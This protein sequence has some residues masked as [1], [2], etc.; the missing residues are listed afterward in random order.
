MTLSENKTEN[1]D[2]HFKIHKQLQNH[3]TW[4]QIWSNYT[5]HGLYPMPFGVVWKIFW[6]LHIKTCLAWDDHIGPA[7]G[8]AKPFASSTDIQAQTNKQ[9]QNKS[10][11]PTG[12]K[13]KHWSDVTNQLLLVQWFIWHTNS[14]TSSVEYSVYT[15]MQT[16][17]RRAVDTRRE[18]E[19]SVSSWMAWTRGTATDHINRC[20]LAGA[21][22]NHCLTHTL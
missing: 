13:F 4:I 16:R 7:N 22:Q 2:I 1:M 6:N 18:N 10:W 15:W 17:I 20:C 8:S 5:S 21:L 14:C 11:H 19:T 3:E 9:K 12:L